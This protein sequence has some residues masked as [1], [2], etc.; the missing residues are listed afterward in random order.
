MKVRNTLATILLSTFVITG[1]TGVASQAQQ[2]RVLPLETTR[3]MVNAAKQN[4]VAF[5][6]Y[7]GKQLI[8]FTNAITHHCNLSALKYWV[9]DEPEPQNWVLPECNPQMPFSIDPTKTPIYFSRPPGS[10]RQVTIQLVYFDGTKT[11]KWTYIP[12]N[13]AGDTACGAL[14]E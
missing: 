2:S 5:R 6:N 4:L 3:M 9:N 14:V 10:I 13:N 7:G 11:P 12:C 8:Y 1:L